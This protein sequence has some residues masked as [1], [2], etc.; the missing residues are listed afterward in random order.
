MKGDYVNIKIINQHPGA[1]SFYQQLGMVLTQ[2]LNPLRFRVL[3]AFVKLSGLNLI[4][5][6]LLNYIRNGGR[7]DWIVGIDLG[8]TSPEALKYL[9]W[10]QDSFSSQVS[11]KIFS[12]GNHFNV[13]HPKLYLMEEGDKLVAWV[14][15]SNLTGGGMFSN[16][17]CILELEIDRL[18]DRDTAEL[19]DA[20]WDSYATPSSANVRLQDLSPEVISEVE[21]KYGPEQETESLTSEHPMA[22]INTGALPRSPLPPRVT[23]EGMIIHS[24]RLQPVYNELLM[25]VLT[26][27]RQTQVQIPVDV[28]TKFFGIRPDEA[29]CITLR[30]LKDGRIRNRPIVHH[31]GMHRIEIETIKDLQRPL[32]IRFRRVSSKL[33]TYDYELIERGSREFRRLRQLLHQKGY[34][35]HS[36]ARRWLPVDS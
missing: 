28:L 18:N 32:I 25:E 7:T 16:F 1:N 30:Y 24:N 20:V 2:S 26:E 35:T 10:L 12:A 19:F 33:D 29:G 4:S 17:E 6:P 9:N 3:S 8:G 15:S 23:K 34:Q 11:I 22:S 27:T 36:R 31:R 21:K 14:G 13:F 5:G